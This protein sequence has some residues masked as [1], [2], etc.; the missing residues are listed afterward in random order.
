VKLKKGELTFLPSGTTLIRFSDEGVVGE[1]VTVK[2][3]TSVA[4][5]G[6]SIGPNKVEY[7]S[8]IYDG[9]SWLAR[10]CDCYEVISRHE[11]D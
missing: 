10:P 5:A 7:Y 3:P 11:N 8:I 4:V 9:Q 1:W 6:G 2:E